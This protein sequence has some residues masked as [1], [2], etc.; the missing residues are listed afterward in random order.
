HP[1][2]H[3][4]AITV[5]ALADFDGLPGS[6]GEATCRDDIDDTLAY[7][8]NYGEDVT[9]IGPGICIYSTYQDGGYAT[10]SGTS[11]SAPHVAGA[12]AIL[13]SMGDYTPA[14]IRDTLTAEGNYDWVDD[15]GDGYH[16]P[17]LDLSTDDDDDFVFAPTFLPEPLPITLTGD[18]Y[19]VGKNQ[20]ADLY[21]TSDGDGL[22]DIYRD[23]TLLI[24][25]ENDGAYTDGI[26]RDDAARIHF[27][28]L[29]EAGTEDTC[30]ASLILYHY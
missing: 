7:F 4:D 3:P 1:A 19:K 28:W 12:A 25:T 14:Q 30:S 11:M 18:A 17:L 26:D 29:C 16:E 6:L 20:F 27:Y 8:S 2:G 24:T 13:A 22:V 23:G 9:M 21:W 15:S 5:S 10:M